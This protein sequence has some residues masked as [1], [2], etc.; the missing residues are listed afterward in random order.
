VLALLVLTTAAVLMMR[1]L[2][3]QPRIC[4]SSSDFQKV[5][6]HAM[7]LCVECCWYPVFLGSKTFLCEGWAGEFWREAREFWMSDQHSFFRSRWD[8]QHG[9]WR[10]AWRATF[11]RAR[12]VPSTI[13]STLWL[14]ALTQKALSGVSGEVSP[15]VRSSLQT[16]RTILLP[17]PSFR[18]ETN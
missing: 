5:L 1:L 7:A 14:A 8:A 18:Q 2:P 15:T 11:W 6:R 10:L 9:E 16:K 4:L 12:Q 17:L 13:A 3:L